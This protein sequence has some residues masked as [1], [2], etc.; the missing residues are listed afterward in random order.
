MRKRRIYLFFFRSSFMFSASRK[1][2][3]FRS[4]FRVRNIHS[5]SK[6]QPDTTMT[7]TTK[8]IIITANE[9]LIEKLASNT[10]T[11]AK[12]IDLDNDYATNKALL[13]QLCAFV[14]ITLLSNQLKV[15]FC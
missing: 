1:I 12:I 6:G 4:C 11:N 8:M 3:F 13:A 14:C 15:S 9:D 10:T 2:T 5:D 7:N